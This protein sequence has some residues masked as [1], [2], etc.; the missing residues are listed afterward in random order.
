MLMLLS[1][2]SFLSFYKLKLKRYYALSLLCGALALLSRENALILF[3][4][5]ILVLFLNKA[6]I[7]S[8]FYAAPF[9]ALNL[10][11]LTIRFFIF[12]QYA[13]PMASGQ[14]SWHLRV[15]NF[16]NIAKEYALLLIFPLNLR[17]FRSTLFITRLLDIR[18][19]ISVLL[20]AFLIIVAVK[21]RKNKLAL[22]SIFW[23]FIGLTPVFMIMD[24]YGNSKEALMAESWIYASSLGFFIAAAVI[25]SKFR[26]IGSI[27]VIAF[28]ALFSS[29]TVVNTLYWENDFVLHNNMLKY[30]SEREYMR[31]N[32]ITYY[33]EH[34]SY[35]R[36]FIELKKYSE[37]F[38]D[39]ALSY[40][41]WGNYNFFG[42]EFDKAIINYNHSLDRD[43]KFAYAYYNLSL[44]YEKLGQ[45]DKALYSA[46][47][48]YKL[49]PYYA[50]NLVCLGRLY[51]REKLFVVAKKYFNEA[52]E[53]E[54]HSSQIK[55]QLKV[56][57]MAAY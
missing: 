55:E 35:E 28:C 25:L 42:G 41:L 52:L 23:F 6:K 21:F 38:P 44:C 32:L 19:V 11:Y 18:G 47:G 48:C 50:R 57:S 31:I 14:L 43:P 29:L 53:I 2:I 7:A 34:K 27:L 30:T 12:G 39:T 51:S 46:M 13:I 5:I 15:I 16:L 22:F 17:L 1:I 8:Y 20:A 37:S 45:H 54:P 33:M 9:I 3:M 49:N 36:A 24:I 56:I 40:M 26:K 10:F 4:F